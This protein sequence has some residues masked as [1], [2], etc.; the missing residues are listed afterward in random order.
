[1]VL[2]CDLV[3]A[4]DE[5]RFGLPEA[6]LGR[7]PLDGGMTLLQRQVPYRKAMGM[8]MTGRRISAREALGMGLINEV[9]PGAELDAAVE[10]WV[11][12]L[13]ACAP[14]S[15]QAIDQMVKRTSSALASGGSGSDCPLSWPRCHTRAR[16][17]C[18]SFREKR[19][20]VWSV[21]LMTHVITSPCID[22]K[23]GACVQCC[24]VDCIYEGGRT[25]YIQPEECIDCGCVYR[26]ARPKRSFTMKNSRNRRPCSPP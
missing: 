13:L 23:D 8:L 25:L 21:T 9:V 10:R 2:G 22:V 11:Q 24:P 12:A 19:K 6:R 5:A 7:M 3:V 16:R 14:L 26:C 1:M 20:P 18:A 15:L 4:C 17:R